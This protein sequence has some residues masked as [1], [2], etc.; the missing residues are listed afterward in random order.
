METKAET[1]P[2]TIERKK[3][4]GQKT[5]NQADLDRVDAM[6]EG[7]QSVVGLAEYLKDV[8]GKHRGTEGGKADLNSHFE[9]FVVREEGD[10]KVVSLEDLQGKLANAGV[11]VEIL[12]VESIGNANQKVS[13]VVQGVDRNNPQSGYERPVVA[14]G[15]H[16]IMA[17]YAVEAN[18]QMHVFRT[19]QYRTGEAVVDTPRGFADSQSLESG[20]QMYEVEGSGERVK[21]N[22]TRVIGEE[23]GEK[24][25]NIKRIVYLGAPRVNSSFVTSKS[26]LFGVEVDYDTFVQSNKVLTDEEFVR[27]R[28]QLEHEG[29][30]GVVIDMNLDQYVNYKRDSGINRD[31]AADS[32]TDIVVMD[33]LADK[34]GQVQAKLEKKDEGRKSFVNLLK[35]MKEKDP[36]EY[37]KMLEKSKN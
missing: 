21:A 30:M 24:L 12:G 8:A 26:A 28:E 1:A 29:L 27:R 35:K 33:F 18:G 16:M 6:M 4:L 20:K 3:P 19:I 13:A 9:E 2:I 17:P 14:E 36:E 25:L 31:I 22:L 15:A 32:A 34:L 37:R 5:I 23:A 10:I 7:K 11:G